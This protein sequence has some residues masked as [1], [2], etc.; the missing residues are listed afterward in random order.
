LFVYNAQAADEIH[1]PES[2]ANQ[3]KQYEESNRKFQM[4]EATKY[5]DVKAGHKELTSDNTDVFGLGDGFGLLYWQYIN[6]NGNNREEIGGVS[7]FNK[8]YAFTVRQSPLGKYV[9]DKIDVDAK[10]HIAFDQDLPT[11]ISIHRCPGLL[12]HGKWLPDVPNHP[13][14]GFLS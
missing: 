4:K 3:W 9:L 13:P 2:V 5:Y 8:N 7:V 14:A 6:F 10:D 12:I 1:L 11:R